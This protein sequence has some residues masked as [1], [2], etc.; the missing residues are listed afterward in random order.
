MKKLL[1]I[2]VLLIIS[3]SSESIERTCDCDVYATVIDRV[4]QEVVLEDYLWESY[5]GTGDD[6]IE[7]V[8]EWQNYN[9]IRDEI[10][11][12]ELYDKDVRVILTVKCN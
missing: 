6:C 1:L 11:F 5:S 3:C 8:V 12:P 2:L 7:V 4:T 10:L 9:P